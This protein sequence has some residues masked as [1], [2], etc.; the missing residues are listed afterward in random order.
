V[1]FDDVLKSIAEVED[2]GDVIVYRRDEVEKVISK[3][4]LL[5]NPVEP[6]NL[7]KCITNLILIEFPTFILKPKESKT[8][9]IK[10]PI[11][12]GVFA[13]DK[14]HKLI[15]II[16]F[17]NQKY[18]LYGDVKS[19]V[20]CR[21]HRSDLNFE[22]PKVDPLKEGILKLKIENRCDD[23]VEMS[24]VVLNVRGMEIYYKDFAFSSAKVVVL[25]KGTAETEFV[26]ERVRGM[27]KSIT[28]FSGKSKFLMEWGLC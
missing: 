20:V 25:N 3:C 14:S 21:Y 28:L 8:I 23:W 19:G 24:R 27:N 7:P 9:F 1:D 22:L 11:E 17:V 2:L 16:T 26:D 10:F 5:A 6:V 15:D 13:I 4:K 18:T 12:I